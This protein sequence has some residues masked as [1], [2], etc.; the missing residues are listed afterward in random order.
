[1]NVE[2]IKFYEQQIADIGEKQYNSAKEYY[3]A[4]TR[5]AELHNYLQKK[6]ATRLH[7][8]RERKSNLGTEM[9]M[10]WRLEEAIQEKDQ[11]FIDNHDEHGICLAKYK[12]LDRAL[13]ALQNNSIAIQS[14]MKWL[15]T[16][17]HFGEI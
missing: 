1:M 3:A 13:D 2:E 17:E 6:L 8:Y 10:L 9:A 15:Q 14:V 5:Y 7:E 12:A 11:E 4:R 16:G